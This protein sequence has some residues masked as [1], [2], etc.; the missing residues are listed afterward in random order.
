MS[1]AK[2]R[3]LLL[4]WLGRVQQRSHMVRHE[5]SAEHLFR[6]LEE[7]YGCGNL[8]CHVA[9]GAIMAMDEHVVSC[10]PTSEMLA[11][12]GALSIESVQ[13]DLNAVCILK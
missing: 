11:K 10:Y 1:L 6:Y 3:T 12:H 8:A 2:L 13:P 9:H 4:N 5:S 7:V